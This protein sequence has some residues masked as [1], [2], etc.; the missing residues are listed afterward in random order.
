VTSRRG[1]RTRAFPAAGSTLS[2]PPSRASRDPRTTRIWNRRSRPPSI[3]AAVAAAFV[4]AAV[5]LNHVIVNSLEMFTALHTAADVG[6]ADYL[7]LA[8]W[9]TLGNMI[10]GML[11][12]TLVRLVQVG[13]GPIEQAP[14]AT[15]STLAPSRSRGASGGVTSDLE[16]VA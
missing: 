13:R 1:L 6:Y 12:V 5:P 7:V 14:A 3:V 4:L 15:V 16:R 9:W 10:G 2:E 11:L 8:S